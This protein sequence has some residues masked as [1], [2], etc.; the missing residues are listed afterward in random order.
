MILKSRNYDPKYT[1]QKQP[2]E[3]FCEKAVLKSFTEFT[4]KLY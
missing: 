1:L 3:V 4:G 2:P